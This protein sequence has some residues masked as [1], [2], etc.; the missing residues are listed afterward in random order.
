MENIEKEYMVT[1]I[2]FA[3]CYL[4]KTLMR[5]TSENKENEYNNC[6]QDRLD[7]LDLDSIESSTTHIFY[8]G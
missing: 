2:T 1:Q 7:L 8:K 4:V 6:H 3:I 5:E